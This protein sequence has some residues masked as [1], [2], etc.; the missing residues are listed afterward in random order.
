MFPTTNTTTTAEPL[1]CDPRGPDGKSYGWICGMNYVRFDNIV[2][3]SVNR[4][5][6]NMTCDAASEER[7][8]LSGFQLVDDPM[9]PA[10][11]CAAWIV[12]F[13][14]SAF[15]N[16]DLALDGDPYVDMHTNMDEYLIGLN[17]AMADRRH[18]VF[19]V[20]FWN[21]IPGYENGPFAQP[22]GY[23]LDFLRVGIAPLAP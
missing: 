1:I 17:P 21:G 15:T 19:M 13:D 4:I 11:P 8:Y 22:I 2:P 18:G 23:A 9:D 10:C 6:I 7:A 14:F 16:P 5:S 3:D 12:G 20:D